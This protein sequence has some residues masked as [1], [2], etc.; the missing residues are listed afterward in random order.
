MLVPCAMCERAG[1]RATESCEG[2]EGKQQQ[3]KKSKSYSNTLLEGGA[4]RTETLMYFLPQSSE[5]K[6]HTK[7]KLA[8]QNQNGTP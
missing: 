1:G 5:T 7:L 6:T 8:S 3:L 2:W 4:E